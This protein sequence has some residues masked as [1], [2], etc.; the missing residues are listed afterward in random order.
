MRKNS[1][2]QPKKTRLDAKMLGVGNSQPLNYIRKKNGAVEKEKK[3]MRMRMREDRRE[4]G[5][6]IETPLNEF[7]HRRESPLA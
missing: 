3:R 7:N 4:D 2:N 5:I 6:Y 1:V